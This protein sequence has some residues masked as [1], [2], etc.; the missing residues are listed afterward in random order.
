[1]AWSGRGKALAAMAL[2]GLNLGALFAAGNL[3]LNGG[4]PVAA[5]ALARGGADTALV[6]FGFPGCSSSCPVTLAR[7]ARAYPELREATGGLAVFFVNLRPHASRSRTRAYVRGFD[8]RFHALAP[9]RPTRA[10]LSRQF[11]AWLY[12]TGPDSE[13]F[14]NPYV[15]LVTRHRGGWQIR[16]R[17]PADGDVIAEIR[18]ALQEAV[19]EQA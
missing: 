19:P 13:P 17:I 14:H 11:G 16:A 10:H 2:V 15:Y 18:Q 8:T 1:M 3:P 7:L 4:K 6:F 9:D 12:R 5:P